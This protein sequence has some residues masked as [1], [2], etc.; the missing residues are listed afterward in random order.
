L[1]VEAL[2]RN[3]AC[4]YACYVLKM[5]SRLVETVHRGSFLDVV[6]LDAGYAHG[7]FLSKR[8]ISLGGAEGNL[9]PGNLDLPPRSK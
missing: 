8:S 1:L 4:R 7:W 5:L 6:I 2:A 3:I 9:W